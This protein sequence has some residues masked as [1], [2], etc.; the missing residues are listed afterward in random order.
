MVKRRFFYFAFAFLS[1]F[2]LNLSH[3]QEQQNV[4]LKD[5]FKGL[6]DAVK[7]PTGV[8][9]P[10]PAPTP[11]PPPAP[12]PTAA[13][14]A[15]AAAGVNKAIN[16]QQTP[17]ATPPA[18][19]GAG[20]VN[21]T[22]IL[23]TPTT[24]GKFEEY[25]S[26]CRT[27]EFDKA[28]YQSP[29]QY[30]EKIKELK[31][32]ADSYISDKASTNSLEA[33]AVLA[34]L[35]S[36]EEKKVFDGLATAVKARVL[37]PQ[38]IAWVNGLI[39]YSKKSYRDARTN[40]LKALTDDEKNES[41]LKIL[42]EVYKAEGNFYEAGAI[43]EDLNREK[44][45][46][47]LPELCETTVLNSLNADGEIIC[48]AAHK[49][50]PNDP[51]PLIFAGITF[52]ERQ[53]LKK[54]RQYFKTSMDVRPTEMGS[55]CLAELSLMENKPQE[56]VEFFKSSVQQSP[57]SKRAVMGLAWSQMKAR[58]YPGA[59]ETFKKACQSDR[60]YEIEVRKAYKLLLEEKYSDAE[61]FMNL[62]LHCGSIK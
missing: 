62:A 56:A 47:Y 35:A 13:A 22:N 44:K 52:R 48:Q 27:R 29:D 1:L 33:L 18:G 39:S 55:I 23:N 15:A 60:R 2:C 37:K 59:L 58:A 12:T 26:M 17:G 14:A 25:L 19:N 16:S 36:L 8:P 20:E 24:A 50:F 30:N 34:E 54:A 32:R 51:F 11:A 53:D 43:Y 31:A 38:E 57:L 45:D 28:Q 3:A 49:K 61:K 40:L 4:N 7:N 9:N 41:I 42:A 10:P 6:N 46:A 5:L 21:S